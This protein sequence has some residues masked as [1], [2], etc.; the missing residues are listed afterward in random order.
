MFRSD[1]EQEIHLWVEVTRVKEKLLDIFVAGMCE[2][3]KMDTVGWKI[4]YYENKILE[5]I[6]YR[7]KGVEEEAASSRN[8]SFSSLMMRQGNSVGRASGRSV[9]VVVGG[10]LLPP[11]CS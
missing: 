1:K 6:R 10:L 2:E 9:N 8:M 3:C 4:N 5:K 11:C 7:M